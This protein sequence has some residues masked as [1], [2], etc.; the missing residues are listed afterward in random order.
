MF[1]RYKMLQVVGMELATALS[2]CEGSIDETHGVAPA[3]T[4]GHPPCC[5]VPAGEAPARLFGTPPRVQAR[6]HR[7]VGTRGDRQR[8][9]FCAALLG[10]SEAGAVVM[11][12]GHMAQGW[13]LRPEPSNRRTAKTG[14]GQ[15]P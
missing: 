15:A 12:A 11:G 6:Q 9:M 3:G 2:G 14:W 1:L 10:Q 13:E 5:M 8:P 7:D 4:H